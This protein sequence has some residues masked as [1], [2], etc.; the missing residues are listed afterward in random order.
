M[1][2]WNF[3]TKSFRSFSIILLSLRNFVPYPTRSLFFSYFK[4]ATV[5]TLCDKNVTLLAAAAA[6]KQPSSNHPLPIGHAAGH[7]GTQ[8]SLDTETTSQA[9]ASTKPAKIE[10]IYGI[11]GIFTTFSVL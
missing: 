9:S 5:H 11:I 3:L 4:I 7:F 10:A 2:F 8:S 1:Q 6:R